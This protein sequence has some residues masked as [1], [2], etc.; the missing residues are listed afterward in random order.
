VRK[1]AR[2]EVYLAETL[3]GDT[4]IKKQMPDAFYKTGLQQYLS[5]HGIKKLIIAGIQTEL[6]VDTT[7]RQACNLE[8]EVT[9]VKDAHST[10]DRDGLTASQMIAHHNAL[11]SDWF[12]TGK[13][14]RDILFENDLASFS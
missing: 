4:I 2:G 7:Y 3:A 13:E 12:V 11:L 8:Y 10:W 6:C 1:Q 14:E 9:L 5:A